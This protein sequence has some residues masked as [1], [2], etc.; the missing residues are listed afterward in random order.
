MTTASKQAKAAGLKS[1]SQASEISTLSHSELTKMYKSNP[2]L[3]KIVILGCVQ[4]L[5]EEKPV[6][7]HWH[8]SHCDQRVPEVHVTFNERH[9]YCGNRVKWLDKRIEG[10]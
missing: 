5:K 7:S 9:A 8:C 6:A 10:E 1:L 4:S 2:E 3:F